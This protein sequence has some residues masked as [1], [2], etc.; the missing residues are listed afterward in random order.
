MTHKDSDPNVDRLKCSRQ[1]KKETDAK[2]DYDLRN[3]RNIKWALGVAGTLQTSGVGQCNRD[4][5]SR[6]RKD[7][8]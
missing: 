7:A 6:K 4:K 2:R 8:Q 3:D 5:N 1:L